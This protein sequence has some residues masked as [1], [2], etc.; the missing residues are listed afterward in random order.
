MNGKTVVVTGAPGWLGTRLVEALTGQSGPWPA[1]SPA[2]VHCVV[3]PGTDDSLLRSLG[4]RTVP[5]DLTSPQ[6]IDHAVQGADTVFHLAGIIHPRRIRDLYALNTNGTRAL[7]EAA[8]RGGVRRF[9][10]VSSNSAGGVNADPR[11][12]LDETSVSPDLHYG[13]SKRLAEIAVLEAHRAAVIE[14]VVV[15]PCWFYGPR[16]P[17][18]QIRF[19]RMIASGRP[20]LFGHGQYR[21]SLSYVD[22]TV[23]GLIRAAVTPRASGQIYWIADERPYSVWEI[24]A[25]AAKHLGVAQLRPR[26]V[27]E[28]VARLSRRLDAATQYAGLYVPEIHVAGEFVEHI[29]CSVDKARKELG[30]R[31]MVGLEEG[32]RLT[33]DWCRSSG[34]L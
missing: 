18:R 2:Q 22:D 16:C 28:W 14:G 13:R 32:M 1:C 33:I 17:Q 7:L 9:I 29:A 4:A 23:Q 8:V 19:Y 26:R 25:A 20:I 30:Y 27:P 15:R 5:I 34:R 6:D 21:R 24:Y 10:Y 12:L 31:P 3:E 11:R